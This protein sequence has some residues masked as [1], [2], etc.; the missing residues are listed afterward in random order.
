MIKN[1]Y[2]LRLSDG[3]YT[4]YFGAKYARMNAIIKLFGPRQMSIKSPPHYFFYLKYHLGSNH[5]VLNGSGTLKQQ[6]HYYSSGL[7]I[8]DL[9]GMSNQRYMFQDKM[10][11]TMHGLRWHDHGARFADNTIFRWTTMDPLC[12]DYYDVSP[13]VYCGN[14][15]VFNVD[16]LGKA[17]GDFF[18]YNDFG[19]K[20]IE[21]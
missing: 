13:Y 19:I 14:K 3:T 8:S 11:D 5:V 7:P 6:I 18:L 21:L 15:P 12:E 16:I 2:N 10:F 20:Y 4:Y 17:L 9:S 1:V